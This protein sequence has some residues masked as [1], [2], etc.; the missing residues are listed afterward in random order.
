MKVNI[1]IGSNLENRIMNRESRFRHFWMYSGVGDRLTG[2]IINSMVRQPAVKLFVDVG[3]NNWSPA[4]EVVNNCWASK[5][6]YKEENE[7][8][9]KWDTGWFNPYILKY[10]NEMEN[11]ALGN[12]AL[13]PQKMFKTRKFSRYMKINTVYKMDKDELDVIKLEGWVTQYLVFIFTG[14]HDEAPL[15]EGSVDIYYKDA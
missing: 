6:L 11:M 9:K 14:G 2:N 4:A 13:E 7:W 15:I 3:G 8:I 12:V 5:F 1:F 10:P